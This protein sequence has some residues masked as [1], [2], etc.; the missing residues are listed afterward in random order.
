MK[1][2]TEEKEGKESVFHVQMQIQDV[3]VT[4]YDVNIQSRKIEGTN[5][6]IV[7]G[8]NFVPLS[9]V[10]SFINKS[11]KTRA[12]NTR[13]NYVYALKYLY[14]FLEIIEKD[15]DSLQLDDFYQLAAFLKGVSATGDDYTYEL[16]TKRSN[17]SVNVYFSVYREYLKYLGLNKSPLFQQSSFSKNIPI[18]PRI[19]GKT[20]KKETVPEYISRDEYMKTM[21]ILDND[22]D[23]NNLRS[24]CIIRIMFEAGLRI[25]EVLGLTLEDLQIRR[26]RKGDTHCV[27]LIR[28]R[29]SSKEFQQ[30]KTCMKITDTRNYNGHDYKTLNVGYQEA[31]IFDSDGIN[32]YDLISEYIDNAHE[33]AAYNHPQHY[34]KTIADS[35]DSFKNENKTNHYLFLNS[36]GGILSDV[37]WNTILREIFIKA[38]L[39]V[40]KGYRKHNLNHRFRHGFVMNLLYCYNIPVSKAKIFSRHKSDASLYVYNNPSIEDIIEMKEEITRDNGV[41]DI[42]SEVIKQ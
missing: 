13:I 12:L 20:L 28:N 10:Y 30:V 27:L 25:G 6:Y 23:I 39:H 1:K 22:E 31:I 42:Y 41:I 5:K 34:K 36:K 7:Y 29:K 37:S 3:C 40:D 26:S 14:T 15:M 2:V 11:S 38:G 8:S 9:D 24:K 17:K 4:K 18:R 21:K 33:S 19:V 32:T 16:L 35:V